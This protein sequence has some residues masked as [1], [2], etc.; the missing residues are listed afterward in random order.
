MWYF[1]RQNRHHDIQYSDLNVITSCIQTS[2]IEWVLCAAFKGQNFEIAVIFKS[3]IDTHCETI[4]NVIE[5]FVEVILW[6]LT[7]YL[8]LRT[9]A[10]STHSHTSCVI[11]GSAVVMCPDCHLIVCTVHFV[12]TQPA[13]TCVHAGIICLKQSELVCLRSLATLQLFVL[14]ATEGDIMVCPQT[15][16]ALSGMHTC[17]YTGYTVTNCTNFS[18][19]YWVV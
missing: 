7:P 12:N 18:E 2:W 13:H 3:V 15:I 17:A 14:D 19:C 4:W 16:C 10:V 5:G 1:N 11:G 9:G 6:P 8:P